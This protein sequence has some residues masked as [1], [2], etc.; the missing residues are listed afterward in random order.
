MLR[1]QDSVESARLRQFAIP[2]LDVIGDGG[3]EDG[4][5]STP[6]DSIFPFASAEYLGRRAAV[7]IRARWSA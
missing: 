4:I 3:I 5:S 2:D 1:Y 7:E 6:S